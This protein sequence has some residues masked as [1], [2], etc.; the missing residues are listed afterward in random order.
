MIQ[1]SQTKMKGREEE[2]EP[3]VISVED[4]EPAEWLKTTLEKLAEQGSGSEEETVKPAEFSTEPV[5]SSRPRTE[6]RAKP[7]VTPPPKVHGSLVNTS[8]DFSRPS[9]RV[10]PITEPTF[11]PQPSTE[12]ENESI[13]A[14]KVETQLP[15]QPPGEEEEPGP[16]V[17]RLREMEITFVERDGITFLEAGT[18]IHERY[19]CEDQSLIDY[20]WRALVRGLKVN[21]DVEGGKVTK[22]TPVS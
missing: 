13:P 5:A 11:K 22:L 20:A 15:A 21:V 7:L 10:E 14:R 2:E 3:H 12:P 18:G 8:S 1:S 17:R 6:E 16:G 9:P 19:P 4:Q